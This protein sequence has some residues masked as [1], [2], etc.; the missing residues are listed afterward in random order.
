MQ[1]TL[2]STQRAA[3]TCYEPEYCRGPTQLSRSLCLI[4][5]LANA[6]RECDRPLRRY[7]AQS[8]CFISC[9]DPQKCA[10]SRVVVAPLQHS[11]HIQSYTTAGA[12]SALRPTIIDGHGAQPAVLIPSTGRH[13]GTLSLSSS[14]VERSTAGMSWSSCGVM[15]ER[16]EEVPTAAQLRFLGRRGA[17]RYPRALPARRLLPHRFPQ[18]IA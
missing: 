1:A 8:A 7:A 16:D 5:R 14:D 2:S 10:V 12:R 9:N 18:R 3:T 15:R 4:Q 17:R 11:L 13:P 6:R